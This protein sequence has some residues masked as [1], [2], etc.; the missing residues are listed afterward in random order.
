MVVIEGLDLRQRVRGKVWIRYVWRVAAGGRD[1]K[2][3]SPPGH[4]LLQSTWGE[5]SGKTRY[6][7]FMDASHTQTK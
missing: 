2:G 6:S 7:T 1:A 3:G 5:N 4:T